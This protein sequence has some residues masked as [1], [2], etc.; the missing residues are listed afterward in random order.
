LKSSTNPFGPSFPETITVSGIHPTLGL[1]IRHDVDRQRCQLVAMTP[2]T[3][4]HRLPQWKS[5][6]RHAFLLYVD[7]TAV[8][9][10]SDVQ[11]EISLA[12][13]AAQ[14]SG[15]VVFTKDEAKNSLSDVGLP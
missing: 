1:D 7:S 14:T 3:P 12:R 2:G 5:L 11:Q 10:I 15:I 9:T 6:L 8:Y 13:Q 4:S